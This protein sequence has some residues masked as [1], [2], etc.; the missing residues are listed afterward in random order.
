MRLKEIKGTG[1]VNRPESSGETKRRAN[2]LTGKST[3]FKEKQFF[4]D[5][6]KETSNKS[7]P[8][9]KEKHRNPPAKIEGVMFVP[10]TYQ[11]QLK[12]HLQA[13]EDSMM[14]Y[15]TVGRTKI[16]ERAGTPLSHIICNQTPWTK[17]GCGRPGC[18]PCVA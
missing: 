3:W 6:N 11:G 1:W 2:R 18:K 5:T 8:S 12:K 17:E 4:E 15:S 10:Y 13:L 14:Q 7:K 9:G 16:V